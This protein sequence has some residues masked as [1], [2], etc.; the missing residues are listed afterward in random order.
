LMIRGSRSIVDK[1][2]LLV[3]ILAHAGDGNMH[4]LIACDT[5]DKDEMERVERAVDEI[6]A[7]AM[8]HNGALTGEH[9]IGVAKMRYLDLGLDAP[10]RQFM[11][12]LKSSIDPLGILNPGKA[13]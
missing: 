5:R 13:I 2:Q 12:Q 8:Q 1:H 3:G 11:Q 9:G 10:T 6:F 4:P 7:L